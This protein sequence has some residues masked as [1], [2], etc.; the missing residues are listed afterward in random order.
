MFEDECRSKLN[1]AFNSLH[2][3]NRRDA[4]C[5]VNSGRTNGDPEDGISSKVFTTDFDCRQKRP[6]A[7]THLTTVDCGQ[8]QTLHLGVSALVVLPV[9]E[10]SGSRELA[11]RSRYGQC[12]PGLV[13][14]LAPHSLKF[15][16]NDK[17]EGR[18]PDG[19]EPSHMSKFEVAY[20]QRVEDTTERLEF[21]KG[22]FD[23]N[24]DAIEQ[25]TTGFESLID[26][27]VSVDSAAAKF[28]ETATVIITGLDELAKVHPVIAV[29]VGAFRLVITLDMTRR[30]NNAKVLALKFA[31][32]D[33]MIVLF[34]LREVED[35]G[36]PNPDGSQRGA[37]IRAL[38]EKIRDD[39][40]E[41]SSACD[42]YMKKGFLARTLKSPIYEK[43]FA[44]YGATF[45]Q[46][47]MDFQ[48]ALA[49]GTAIGV[50]AIDVKVQEL[51]E[52]FRRMS[53]SQEN[54]LQKVLEDNGGPESC[55]KDDKLLARLLSNSGG[56]LPGKP[57]KSDST[58][59]A[60]ELKNQRK[61]LLNEMK[62]DV[63]DMFE[64][65]LT[66]FRG[67]LAMQSEHLKAIEELNKRIIVLLESGSHEKIVDPSL[68][69]IW[70]EMGWRSSV[71]ARHFVLALH[72]YYSDGSFLQ[73][74]GQ[75]LGGNSSL[76]IADKLTLGEDRWALAYINVGHVQPIV[77]AI[78][79]DGTQ[80]VSIK[81]V[82][83]FVT[84]SPQGWTLPER[85]A[86][87]AAG[88]R[89][90]VA[91]Y[92]TKI[93]LQVQ[94]I[95]ELLD[96][97]VPA[98]RTLVEAYLGNDAL[99]R[100]EHILRSTKTAEPIQYDPNLTRLV[101]LFEAAE[102]ER[103]D[104]NLDSV[105][106]EVDSVETI[107]LVTGPGRIERYLFPLVHLLLK[108]DLDIIV[109]ACKYVLNE[110]EL[111]VGLRSLQAVF[112]AVDERIGRIT[113]IIK[114]SDADVNARLGFYAFG[115]F[116]IYYEKVYRSGQMYLLNKKDNSFLTWSRWT[117][118]YVRP[119]TFLEDL[120]QLEAESIPVT[121]LKFGP[122]DLTALEEGSMN[123]PSP[124]D[125]EN[126][127][128]SL[129]VGHWSGH[130]W[131]DVLGGIVSVMDLIE[132]K[133]DILPGGVI[134]GTGQTWSTSFIINGSFDEN[135]NMTFSME[136]DNG[137]VIS[138]DGVFD[139]S[140]Q[141]IEG[142]WEQYFGYLTGPILFT[143]TP[144]R[145]QKF[146]V[147]PREFSRNPARA[148]WTFACKAVLHEV[149]RKSW[150]W[151]HFEVHMGDVRRF[152]ALHTRWLVSHNKMTSDNFNNLSR[153]EDQEVSALRQVLDVSVARLCF[154]LARFHVDR[155]VAKHRLVVCDVCWRAMH[156][157]RTICLDC[158]PEDFVYTVD[159]C[160]ACS[161][162]SFIRG[163][164]GHDPS[165]SMI[166]YEHTVFDYNQVSS[167][168]A[169]AE[170]AKEA[171]RTGLISNDSWTKPVPT[172]EI[173]C[174][175]CSEAVTI[176][177]WVC[178]DCNLNVTFV[179]VECEETKVAPPEY[180]FHKVKHI[181]I[182]IGTT[183]PISSVADTE[184]SIA[185]LEE[186]VDERLAQLEA[187]VQE[188]MTQ[189][190]V[191]AEKAEK[192]LDALETSIE[193]RF[194]TIEGLLRQIVA[195]P[196]VIPQVASP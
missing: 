109:L 156:G 59:W 141:R 123:P 119:E 161:T 15:V 43:R 33:M 99:I 158:F 118:G 36:K 89:L 79:D 175:C 91:S 182:R 61:A 67:K 74:Q 21:V 53:S 66:I 120:N 5:S 29:A 121:E 193:K 136:V 178:R 108:H 190:R 51:L 11:V 113:G 157:P 16:M 60:E 148:R 143:R 134:S 185:A 103:L 87:W 72:D 76:R 166:T 117:D 152:V 176:P 114:Q 125:V 101:D 45:A 162:D 49:L 1:N 115:M 191:R 145:L 149:R 19:P 163:N 25:T 195:R 40:E 86:Y 68:R 155:L 3:S 111:L 144:T 164:D 170:R 6:N 46:N 18:I 104:R 32:Q 177:C 85:L 22:F 183:N 94:K 133:I 31:M 107:G 12:I 35:L 188:E 13:A 135:N 57:Q 80:F 169:I 77:E 147:N 97:L 128:N 122:V 41:A 138:C 180:L 81:E 159:L 96:Q 139:H 131:R 42:A 27:A 63:D 50:A 30:K 165:H 26:G 78:D 23:E 55:I 186:K 189:L 7:K 179:C 95:F 20:D 168:Q 184:A 106:Y 98:N 71:K 150:S 64:N 47:K 100:L 142:R 146:W 65:H 112:D 56:T 137:W 34:E 93:Y 2:C 124:Y 52:G 153:E 129:P 102:E 140:R 126:P 73:L 75:G 130:L 160:K 194:S 187:V 92:K 9:T 38:I 127:H 17:T 28:F 8:S 181:L 132:L 48:H 14:F 39:I 173:L 88:W 116:Q 196:E 44:E 105:Q 83:L 37:R 82:N 171:F 154:A 69:V 110:Q 54:F 174:I 58:E 192:Q 62:E 10:F 151:A 167:S 4:V 24:Q 90:S 84:S 70:K 172:T